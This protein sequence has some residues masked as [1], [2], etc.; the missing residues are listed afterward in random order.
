[1]QPQKSTS[2]TAHPVLHPKGTVRALALV[3]F[4]VLVVAVAVL[5][6]GSVHLVVLYDGLHVWPP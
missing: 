2:D 4:P 3:I 1:M 5:L 6:K